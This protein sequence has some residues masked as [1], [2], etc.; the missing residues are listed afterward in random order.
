MTEYGRQVK[1]NG[2]Y[3]GGI[4]VAPGH[5]AGVDEGPHREGKVCWKNGMFLTIDPSQAET[6][7]Q[8]LRYENSP[9]LEVTEAANRE[10]FRDKKLTP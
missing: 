6:T 7:S 4:S 1:A 3:T 8:L 5:S 10:S 9:C 2:A